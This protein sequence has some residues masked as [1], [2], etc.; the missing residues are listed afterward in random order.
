MIPLSLTLSAFGPFAKEVTLDFK[1]IKNN[2]F[3]II[4]PTGSGKTTL[5]DAIS[6]ALFGKASGLSRTPDDFKSDFADEKT[7]CFVEFEFALKDKIFKIKRFAPYVK[8]TNKNTS[9]VIS[10]KAILTLD[11]GE[12]IDN[13]KA[14]NAKIE[15]LLGVNERQFKQIVMLPQ[16]EFKRL[17]EAKSDE[18]QIIF[19][20]IFSTEQIDEFT[21]ILKL[22]SKEL[23]DYTTSAKNTIFALLQSVLGSLADAE[24]EAELR[25][26][27]PSIQKSLE[28][29]G[30]SIKVQQGKLLE[31]ESV[32]TNL[33][34]SCK[35]LTLE[36][37]STERLNSKIQ[38]RAALLSQLEL[39]KQS[40][41]VIEK[42]KSDVIKYRAAKDLQPQERLLSD[43]QT[44][45]E[46]LKT[47][48]LKETKQN[49]ALSLELDA[50]KS[51][52][53]VQVQKSEQI[54]LYEQTIPRLE[55]LVDDFKICDDLK[56]E[57]AEIKIQKAKSKEK[58]NLIILSEQW[59]EIKA[60]I[61]T[62]KLQESSITQIKNL[63]Q[64]F[65]KLHQKHQMQKENYSA[66][67][68]LFLEQQAGFLA[69]TLNDAAPCPVCGSTEHP[70]IAVLPAKHLTQ[71]MLEALKTALEETAQNLHQIQLKL[72][73]LFNAL[74]SAGMFSFEFSDIFANEEQINLTH[75]KLTL[76]CHG[77][78]LKEQEIKQQVNV[79]FPA[80]N[81]LKNKE[82]N[83]EIVRAKHEEQVKT[84][85]RLELQVEALTADLKA[86]EERNKSLYPQVSSAEEIVNQIS[87]LKAEIN[88]HEAALKEL[89]GLL[90]EKQAA[91]LKSESLIKLHNQNITELL[92]QIESE[93]VK[94][95]AAYQSV[96]FASLEEYKTALVLNCT[97]IEAEIAEYESKKREVLTKLSVLKEDIGAN[98]FSKDLNMLKAKCKESSD[99]LATC[100]KECIDLSATIEICLR[101]KNKVKT[102]WQQIEKNNNL[103][104]KTNELYRLASGQNSAK[105]S[106]ERFVLSSY[107]DL[108]IE[109]ANLK[110]RE[111]TMA[112][113]KLQ[114]KLEK[115]KRHSSG[116]DL[117]IMDSFT[118]KPRDVSTLSGGESFKAALA[119]ALALSEVIANFSGGT[120]IDTMF[121]DEGF[122]TLDE[123]ALDCAIGVL[124]QLKN[125][126]RMIGIISHV[127][128]LKDR[129]KDK[130]IVSAT[131]NGSYAH[132]LL[133]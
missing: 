102:V 78:E 8:T 55:A 51:E 88:A 111:M 69:Q 97:A 126:G 3:L 9:R 125:T 118:G 75:Q 40:E 66:D 96:G 38:E 15:E 133:S 42:A 17:L 48:L 86:K 121:I 116:L 90:E 123:E 22:K 18:K 6:F 33:E 131:Q 62:L 80:E 36:L 72:Q 25:K 119:L 124:M 77:L 50:L 117:E 45:L 19:R 39:L 100:Q 85:T 13:L 46:Q 120:H 52:L 65:K 128:E 71:Q 41:D 89:A 107:F 110:L 94:F 112:R 20:R 82:F 10:S 16:G 114:R 56:V 84:D 67:Y 29:L 49:S 34:S 23:T 43:K 60:Q 115:N 2:I 28:L 26:S 70:K 68:K 31:L 54:K 109:I 53:A 93:S 12:V 113:Y 129:I 98:T 61:D 95:K 21:N 5:F 27:E 35:E 130:L 91:F 37:E 108:I 24:L 76:N 106:F 7:P 58:L 127:S 44:Q 30:A 59:L 74:H 57:L 99:A 32:R 14:V 87:K 4:G 132:F 63:L 79:L 64:T 81:L 104:Y 83:L 122:G 11:S 47:V 73:E 92:A 101:T 1:N 103:C 105:L